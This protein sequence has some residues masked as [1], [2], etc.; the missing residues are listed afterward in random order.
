MP[1]LRAEDDEDLSKQLGVELLRGRVALG[2]P[3]GGAV[4]G[5]PVAHPFG[6]LAEIDEAGAQRAERHVGGLGPEAVQGL[7]QGQAAVLLDRLDAD[8]AVA[9]AA[10][11]DHADRALALVEGQGRQE[12]V[13]RLGLADLRLERPQRQPAVHDAHDDTARHDVDAARPDRRAV[14]GGLDLQRREPGQDV[15]EQA[16][17]VPAE[18][19]DDDEGCPE[20]LRHPAEEAL[21]RFDAARGRADADDR[22]GVVVHHDVLSLRI[23]ATPF[24]GSRH[25][26]FPPDVEDGR[27]DQLSCVASCTT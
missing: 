26:A 23:D 21:H 8:G 11:Q 20:R 15:R 4:R 19:R 6:R 1:D 13:D 3:R 16:P 22:K 12:D 24:V 7:G 25:P 2:L 17:V 10:G 14:G 27:A 5:D 9:V 18:M